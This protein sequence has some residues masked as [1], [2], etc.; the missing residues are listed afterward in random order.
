MRRVGSFQGEPLSG[1]SPAW[2]RAARPQPPGVC[3]GAANGGRRGARQR[4]SLKH[5]TFIKRLSKALVKTRSGGRWC[6]GT[7]LRSR[8]ALEVKAERGAEV[9]VSTGTAR[10]S[11]HLRVDVALSSQEPSF[12][13]FFSR[14]V[15]GPVSFIARVG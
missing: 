9:A 3:D 14:K 8:R 12:P 6:G 11:A 5:R 13:A 15:S 7:A 1:P 2:H 4:R 10:S